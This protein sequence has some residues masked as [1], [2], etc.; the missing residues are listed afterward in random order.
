MD[1][2]KGLHRYHPYRRMKKEFNGFTE[3][4]VSREPLTGMQVYERIK[5]VETIFGKLHKVKPKKGVLWKKVSIF[6]D[7]PYWK[8]LSVRHCL[9][10]M[11]IEKNVCDSLIGTLLNIPGKTKDG[12]SV[13][14]DM[15]ANNIRPKLWPEDNDS[16]KKSFLPHACYTLTREEKRIFCECL[17]GIKVPTG[18]SSNVRRLVS[19]ADKRLIGMK[20]HDCHVMMQVFLPI[21]LRG[22]LS[23]HVRY[24][25]VKLC[26]FFNAICSKVIDPGKLDDMQ[27]DIVETLCKFEMYFP[28][29]FFDI[30]VHLVV[31]LPREIK[32]CGPV[33]LRY[34]YP[35]ERHMGTLQDKAKNKANPEGSIIR[36]IMAEE[37]GNFCAVFLA[38]AKEIGVPI[39]R[40]EGRLHGKGTIGRK[41]IKPPLERFKKAHRCVL[42]SLS[43][44]HPYIEKHQQELQCRNRRISA[45]ALMQEHNRDFVEWFQAQVK[46]EVRQNKS[47]SDTIMWLSR[48]AQPLVYTY[49][50]YDINGFSFS[51]C[52]QDEKSVQQNSGVVVVA[53]STE[54]SSAKDTRPIDAKQSYYGVIQEIWELDYVDFTIPLF[55]CT[56][57]D[58][59]RGQKRDELFGFTLVDSSRYTDSEEPFILASQAKQIFYI[60]DNIDPQWRV[61]VQGKRKIVGVED[62]VDEE[63]YDKL[64]DTP[65][66]SIGVQPLQ[67]GEDVVDDEEYDREE[68][69]EVDYP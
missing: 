66:L 35:Y 40:H 56:W 33:F 61:V 6:W 14:R 31:H 41:M 34:M 37:A 17:Q 36:G 23:K 48:G 55:R 67:E 5:D 64:D 21:A 68:G 59:R 39:S 47:V 49:E 28:P 2:R 27:V 16:T 42:Q 57:A 26:L 8:H 24:A 65:P 45:Y 30:M 69:I 15:K 58:N 3:R 54:Y 46:L 22:L 20:S 1:H 62:V 13:R 43:E 25:I 51:T 12:A 29:S 4:R 18:F 63:E 9:D 11:H 50:G 7:L 32:E 44:V 53:S 10:V 60:K 52:R 38:R 19:M